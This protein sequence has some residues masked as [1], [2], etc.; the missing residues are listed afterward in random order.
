[1]LPSVQSQPS[2]AQFSTTPTCP[3]LRS[4]GEE[5][6]IALPISPAQEAVESNEVTLQSPFLQTKQVLSGSS[7]DM[8]SDT[9]SGLAVLL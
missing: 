2:L 7:Q 5:M 6:G 4:Q 1:M 9:L 3:I 8:S